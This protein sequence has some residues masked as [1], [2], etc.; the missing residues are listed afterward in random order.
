MPTPILGY[1][2]V[3][4]AAQPIRYLLEYVGEP[5]EEKLYEMGPGFEKPQW[6]K[7][8]F[9]LGLAFPNLP[10]YIHGDVKITGSITIARYIANKHNLA[11]QTE[12]EKLQVDMLQQVGYDIIWSEVLKITRFIDPSTM[13][14]EKAKYISG[15]LKIHLDNF[16]KYLG[17]KKFFMG[18][19]VT[20]VDFYLYHMFTTLAGFAPELFN[21]YPTFKTYMQT[22]EALP[23]IAKYMK[24]E[25]YVKY[26]AN[27]PF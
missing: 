27:A 1:L 16:S 14:E 21:K 9:T 19:N 23:A 12:E 18:D 26:F 11:G 7:E 4:G 6:L 24:S 20:Y 3:R 2:Y 8:R 5:Y 15:Q 17:N 22:I 10:Y 25:K 13:E